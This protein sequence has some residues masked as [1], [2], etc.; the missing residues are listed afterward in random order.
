MLKIIHNV[1]KSQKHR[2]LDH[3]NEK[4]TGKHCTHYNEVYKI[5]YNI[6]NNQYPLDPDKD[7]QTVITE[8]DYSKGL[9]M[10]KKNTPCT[11]GPVF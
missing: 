5:R 4:N 3:P 6:G 10:A 7:S 8:A 2:C 9:Q 11:A 1:L